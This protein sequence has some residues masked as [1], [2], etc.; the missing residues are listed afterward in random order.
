MLRK[1]IGTNLF[2]LNKILAAVTP[3][4]KASHFLKGLDL[5]VPSATQF[6]NKEFSYKGWGSRLL[7]QK[8]ILNFLCS[9]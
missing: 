2:V 7:T 4:A 5:D 3:S 6:S 1:W 9:I 8:T